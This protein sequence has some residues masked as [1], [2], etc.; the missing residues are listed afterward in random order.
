MPEGEIINIILEYWQFFVILYL[1][2]VVSSTL[3][4]ALMYSIYDKINFYIHNRRI[5]KIAKEIP[6]IPVHVTYLSPTVPGG[7]KFTTT[8][9]FTTD[10]NQIREALAKDVIAIEYE[11][12]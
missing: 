5:K 6:M 1:I 7:I 4:Y 12:R 11:K 10:V 8:I 9:P 3:L 2:L